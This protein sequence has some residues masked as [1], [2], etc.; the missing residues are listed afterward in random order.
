MLRDDVLDLRDVPGVVDAD[1]E[2]VEIGVVQR[3]RQRVDVDGDRRRAGPAEGRDDVDPL[4]CAG[5]E[6]RCHGER[7]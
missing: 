6:D 5:E 4:P 1:H 3:G 2:L 7:G